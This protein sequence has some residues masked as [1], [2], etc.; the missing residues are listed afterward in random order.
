MKKFYQNY[1][2]LQKKTINILFLTIKININTYLQN[3]YSQI[4]VLT[5]D[6][7]YYL[8]SFLLLSKNNS[9]KLPAKGSKG[10]SCLKLVS[11]LV[12]NIDS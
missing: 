6:K 10:Y 12:F 1:N 2:L 4:V 8:V 7:K 11:A 5:R 3:F 9:P